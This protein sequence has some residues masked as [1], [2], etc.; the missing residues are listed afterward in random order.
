MIERVKANFRDPVWQGLGVIIAVLAIVVSVFLNYDI[1]RKQKTVTELT[2]STFPSYV[3]PLIK[4]TEDLDIVVSV[5]GINVPA[6]RI[7][8]Y[9][10]ENTGTEAIKTEDF[11]QKLRVSVP[12]P[13]R[14][15]AISQKKQDIEMTSFT[16]KWTREDDRTFSLNPTFINPHESATIV[17]N[18]LARVRAVVTAVFAMRY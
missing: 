7:D 4:E 11:V 17:L 1:N 15:L 16:T 5:N 10:I 3:P 2:V 8:S 6:I 13:L 9:L 14:I 12:D 18:D